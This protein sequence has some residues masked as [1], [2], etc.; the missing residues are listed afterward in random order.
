M[1]NFDELNDDSPIEEVNL[2]IELIKSKIPTYTSTKLCEMIV[3]DRYFGFNKE[4]NVICM[5]ELAKRR[6]SGDSFDF[7][8]FIEESL[9]DLPPLDFSNVLDI[10]SALNQAMSLSKNFNHE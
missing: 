5:E 8:S 10:K 7:E 4:I 9:K 3:C 2:D 6:L 1:E